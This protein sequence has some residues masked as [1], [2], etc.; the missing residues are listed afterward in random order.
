ATTAERAAASAERDHELVRHREARAHLEAE[1][2]RMMLAKGMASLGSWELDLAAGTTEWSEGMCRLAGL[3]PADIAF[4][5]DEASQRLHPDDRPVMQAYVRAMVEGGRPSPVES[6]IV[7]P[8]GQ[9][10]WLQSAMTAVGPDRWVGFSQDITERRQR[11]QAL[12]E[13]DERLRL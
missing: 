8:D 11:E 13:H 4:T 5:F 9:V 10:R 7:R 3:E 1:R 2:Q 12:R 6:R